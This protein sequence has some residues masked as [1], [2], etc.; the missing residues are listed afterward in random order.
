MKNQYKFCYFCKKNKR[1]GVDMYSKE[2]NG[3]QYIVCV[4]CSKELGK[5]MNE[6]IEKNINEKSCAQN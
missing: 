6:F 4:E 3:K 2:I 5:M 1:Y